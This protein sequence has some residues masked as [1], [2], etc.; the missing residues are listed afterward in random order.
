LLDRPRSGERALLLHVGLHRPCS[1]DETQEFRALA[2]SAGAT[3]VAEV[4]ARRDRPDPRF[5]I[6]SG[7]VEEV[8]ARVLESKAELILVSQPLRP[9]QERNLETTLKTRVLDRN[10]LI[11][12]IFAQRA[13]T[14]EGK[15]QV[16]LA[17]HE[18]LASRLVRGWTHL[19][20]QKGGIG[21]RGPGETQLETDRRLVSRRIRH[22][23]ER[24]ARVERQREAS[25]KERL[26]AEVP[27]VALVGYTNAG[28]TT[29]F[30]ALSGAHLLARDQLFATLDPTV[31]RLSL[32][33]GDE[34]LL[35]DTVGFVRDLP[36]E[37]VAA[38]RA[39]LT[40]TRE[41]ALL[42]HVIDASDP[43]HEDRRRQVDA[44]LADIGAAE[45]PCLPV[46]NKIDRAGVE[47]VREPSG[48]EPSRYGVSAVTGEG[49]AELRAG[50][51]S[52]VSGERV[53]GELHLGPQQSRLRAKLFEW[54]A[55]R[56]ESTAPDGGWNLAVELPAQRWRQLRDQEGLAGTSIRRKV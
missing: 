30:N 13:A 46:Y 15:L 12:D 2:E 48:S 47:F 55:V 50:I 4:H 38:F 33:G 54:H 16:E 17:Q 53:V 27:T 35:V 44:V 41:A 6:G 24:L 42:L 37:L 20:R 34:V 5:L 8:A 7:K 26:R 45:V 29:L 11:L 39:T 51:R 10:G 18:H 52:R 19:E 56:S 25:R 21:L 49:L 9:G 43:H 31:R 22:L 3:V 23:R 14:F 40:E 36:H 1:E 28:K 32:G